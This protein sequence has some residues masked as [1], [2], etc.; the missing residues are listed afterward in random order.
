[1]PMPAE[2]IPFAEW[3]ARQRAEG[4]DWDR[5]IRSYMRS[6]G[7]RRKIP[8]VVRSKKVR[9]PARTGR[10]SG[11]RPLPRRF[12]NEKTNETAAEGRPGGR[13]SNASAP[14]YGAVMTGQLFPLPGFGSVHTIR[15]WIDGLMGVFAVT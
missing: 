5:T 10:A 13:P 1:M 4:P 8:S 12:T 15:P 6:R 2:R 3:E 11:A 14:S 7:S 9:R